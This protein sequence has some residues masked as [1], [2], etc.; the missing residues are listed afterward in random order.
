MPFSSLLLEMIR[1]C[2]GLGDIWTQSGP[3]PFHLPL[4]NAKGPLKCPGAI[5]R[6]PKGENPQF[7]PLIIYNFLKGSTEGNKIKAR[8]HMVYSWFLP[9]STRI[10]V[11]ESMR[12]SSS[13]CV[14]PLLPTYKLP[15][16]WLRELTCRRCLRASLWRSTWR[17]TGHMSLIS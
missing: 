11:K 17:C 15:N 10:L 9:H 12:L 4:F 6:I 1:A 14:V 13:I 8:C 16:W 5:G 2:Y 3:L 7:F